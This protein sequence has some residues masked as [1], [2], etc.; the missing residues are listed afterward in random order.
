VV[1]SYKVDLS[2]ETIPYTVGDTYSYNG[3]S[4]TLNGAPTNADTFT[5]GATLQGAAGGGNGGTGV[6][7]GMP[8]P[9]NASLAATTLTYTGAGV[10]GF[11]AGSVTVTT[12]V[13]GI[14]TTTTTAV[15]GVATVVPYVPAAAPDDKATIVFTSAAAPTTSFGFSLTGAPAAGDTFAFS[16]YPTTGGAN[17][18]T[19]AITQ[20]ATPFTASLPTSTY[21]LTYDKVN[22]KIYGFPPGVT[23]NVTTAAGAL[24]AVQITGPTTGV[25]YSQGMSVAINDVSIS[26]L[27][28]PADGDQFTVGPTPA[29]TSDNRNAVN[30]TFLQTRKTLLGGTA[31]F[32]EAY[33]QLVS[34]V[35]NKTREIDV[36][37]QSQKTQLTQ[38]T[39]AQQ[40]FS[41]VNLD[42]EAGNLLRFQQA[43]Q[44]AAKVIDIAS[45]LF[46]EL[47][48]LGR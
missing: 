21:T 14:T 1:T 34:F 38:A 26:F 15:A 43:Y 27:G 7:A 12:T 37:S 39:D 35:G 5:V 6:V 10:S 22:N 41:G 46:E 23:V 3:L 31:T 47:I 18:G 42:E 24:S 19:G 2:N 25:T 48:S 8:L 17:A 29:G 28:T 13:A 32:E 45:K 16:R 20:A 30:L 36:A 9:S 11:A 4:F 33:A 44:A 40:S